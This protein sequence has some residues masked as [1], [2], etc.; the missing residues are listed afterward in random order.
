MDIVGSLPPSKGYS[1]LFTCV[2]RY[3]RWPEAVPMV[4]TTPEGLRFSPPN[5]LDLTLWYSND[6]HL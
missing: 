4:D 6:D 5:G 2:D 3:T 1:Y